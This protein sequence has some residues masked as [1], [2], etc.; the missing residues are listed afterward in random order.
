M[1]LGLGV[2]P[3][4]RE[5]TAGVVPDRISKGTGQGGEVHPVEIWAL[6][7]FAG[8]APC[9]AG[10]VS[11][12]RPRMTAASRSEAARMGEALFCQAMRP[13]RRGDIPAIP[14]KDDQQQLLSGWTGDIGRRF[15]QSLWAKLG[16]ARWRRVRLQAAAG[17]R[18]IA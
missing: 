2:A 5:K 10:S 13:I 16:V 12:L 3:Q 18:R 17:I 14:A 15:P 11:E 6:P 4:H 1:A 7:A 8:G 9:P